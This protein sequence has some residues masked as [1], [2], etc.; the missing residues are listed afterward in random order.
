MSKCVSIIAHTPYDSNK[1]NI[2]HLRAIINL[3]NW[4]L[5]FRKSV[6][7]I[8]VSVPPVLYIFSMTTLLILFYRLPL[9][10]IVQSFVLL[11]F[12]YICVYRRLGSCRWFRCGIWCTLILWIAAALWITILGR[13][14]NSAHIPKLIPFHSYRELFATVDGEI[15]RTNFMNVALFYPAGLLTV[16][17]F[18]QRWKLWQKILFTGILLA[19]FSLSIEYIQFSCALGE[20]EIDDVIH[21]TIGAIYGTIPIVC[22]EI[23]H[24]PQN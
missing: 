12:A 24:Y 17:L 6:A 10:F 22:N 4:E 2:A 13:S 16:S 1:I 11:S 14:P 15:I 9:K 8:T 7:M 21:N 5:I 3:L 19:M 18:F 23:L 20:P